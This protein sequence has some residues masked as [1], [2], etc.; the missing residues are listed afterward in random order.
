MPPRE[1]GSQSAK[2]ECKE[3]AIHN[4]FG[5]IDLGS[6][7]VSDFRNFPFNGKTLG[8]MPALIVGSGVSTYLGFESISVDS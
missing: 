8:E 1:V 7:R 3:K 6:P 5:I 4:A 2:V